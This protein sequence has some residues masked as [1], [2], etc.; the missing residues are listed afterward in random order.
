MP[1]FSA[2]F[3]LARR[4]R[5]GDTVLKSLDDSPRGTL[6]AFLNFATVSDELPH[7]ADFGVNPDV[8]FWHKADILIAWANVRFRG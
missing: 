5:E 8:R 1:V 3:V 2:C 6:V 4:R 7:V